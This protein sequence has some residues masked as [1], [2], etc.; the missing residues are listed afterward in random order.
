[1]TLN[2]GIKQFKKLIPII[3]KTKV[4]FKIRH[5]TGAPFFF[6]KYKKRKMF[7]AGIVL[8]VGMICFFSM[9][10]WDI[11]I[12]GNS[13]LTDEV[14]YKYLETHNI[15]YGSY[16]YGIDSEELEKNLRNE[17]N[18]II[19]ASVEKK[20]TRLVIYIQESL[21][22]DEN[23]SDEDKALQSSIYAS[24]DGKIVKMITRSGTPLVSVG[25]YVTAGSILVDG[26]IDIIGD[27]ESVIE[28]KMCQA[29]ADIYIETVYNY[30]DKFD[31]KHTEK[32]ETKNSRKKYYITIFSKTIDLSFEGKKYKN[33]ESITR[34]V[35]L[36]LWGDFYLP[37]YIG[38]TIE[39][40]YENY[41][42]IY[43]KASAKELA[44]EHL[45]QFCNELQ[46]KGVQ[47][48]EKD[49]KITMD[50]NSCYADGNIYVIEKTG[51]NKENLQ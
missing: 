28:T 37:V 30:S 17:Y 23:K 51:E 50:S 25:T 39:K 26:K 22:P 34:Q 44:N 38:K 36:K 49:V 16:K 15:R 40:E 45:Q 31:L 19:W 32:K 10:V 21:L 2:V 13:T 12:E 41:S 14:I 46:R 47:I 11:D 42:I 35:Q 5:K 27:D 29:D 18:E 33:Q 43:D 8:C 6:Y 4:K 20:G 9:F 48:V 3:R 24:K 1:M 7:F